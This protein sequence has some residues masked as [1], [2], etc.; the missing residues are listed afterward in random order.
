MVNYRSTLLVY[1]TKE[2]NINEQNAQELTHA[3]FI[4]RNTHNIYY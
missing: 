4:T 2:Y 1:I 3:M